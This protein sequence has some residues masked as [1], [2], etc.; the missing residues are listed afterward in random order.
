MSFSV[1]EMTFKLCLSGAHSLW[2]IAFSS[3]L[4]FIP[5]SLNTVSWKSSLGGLI[6]SVN[7]WRPTNMCNSA[8][9]CLP[10]HKHLKWHSFR[11]GL[12]TLNVIIYGPICIVL[13][14]SICPFLT[15]DLLHICHTKMIEIIKQNIILH[16]DT[17]IKN[18]KFLIFYGF[19]Y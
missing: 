6:T 13:E 10:N 14:K 18:N 7:K 9:F 4:P 3:H 12:T 17:P 11:V 5:T 16:I 8:R 19:I 15:F 1:K 2:L